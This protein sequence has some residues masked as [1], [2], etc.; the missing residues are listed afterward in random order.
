MVSSRSFLRFSLV[1]VTLATVQA[2]VSLFRPAENSPR[3]PLT[4]EWVLQSPL[5]TARNLWGAAWATPTHAFAV[6]DGLTMIETFDAGATW[7]DV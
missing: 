7:R 3:A 1:W 6:G 5:P 2:E 4:E